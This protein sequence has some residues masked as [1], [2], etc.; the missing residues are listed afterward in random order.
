MRYF[1]AFMDLQ[2]QTVLISGGG[3]LAVRK[4]RLL[5]PSG[6]RI[7]A[8][9]ASEDGPLARELSDRLILR[10]EP[11]SDTA[12]RENIRLVVAATGD[13]AEDERVAKLG[14]AHGV[15]VNAVDMPHLCDVVIPSIVERG[16]LVIGISTGGATPVL[17]RRLRE[18]LEAMLPA[19]LGEVIAFAKERRGRVA[20]A[21]EPQKRR[22]FWERFFSGAASD[23]VLSRDETRAEALFSEELRGETPGHV[24]I[25]GAGPGDPELLTLKALR[26]CQ[27]ADVILHDA[28]VSD[29]VLALCRRDAERIYVGK[30]RANHALPQPEIGALMVELAQAGKR[31]VRLKGGDPFIFGRGGEEL[32]VLE[33]AG[34]EASVIPGITAATGCA[35]RAELPLTHRGLSQSVTFV[36]AE[37]GGGGAPD[38]DWKALASVGGTIAVYMG[39]RR[40]GDVAADL[41]RGGLDASTPAAVIANGTL[42]TERIIRA[43]LA[44]LGE[45]ADQISA[46]GLLVIGDVAAKAK[47]EELL[48]LARQEIAA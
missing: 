35:A 15:P 41:M 7:V 1:P 34:V 17:G 4:A 5:L 3:E 42:P 14:R 31:V 28:L 23:A 8:Y 44:T 38:I 10:T 32:E 2:G 36:T 39:V 45:A 24:H 11:I 21:L 37:A 13:E 18:K 25:V 20:E 12:F 43:D 46:P 26:V 40:A 33:A 29:E 6:A 16:D 30:K 27:E 19:R 47:G 48:S 22:A 9:H